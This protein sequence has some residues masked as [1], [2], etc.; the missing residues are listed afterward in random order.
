MMMECG[1]GGDDEGSRVVGRVTG[2]CWGKDGQRKGFD[3]W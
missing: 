2:L 3:R 1:V